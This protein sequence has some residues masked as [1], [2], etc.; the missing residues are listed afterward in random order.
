MRYSTQYSSGIQGPLASVSGLTDSDAA[1]LD[2]LLQASGPPPEK[3]LTRA[4]S[5]STITLSSAGSGAAATKKPSKKA[6]AKALDIGDRDLLPIST[7][8]YAKNASTLSDNLIRIYDRIDEVRAGA[9]KE[10]DVLATSLQR[11]LASIEGLDDRVT[12]QLMANMTQ[13]VNDSVE[14]RLQAVPA[15]AS[16]SATQLRALQNAHNELVASVDSRLSELDRLTR[17]AREDFDAL[18]N[19]HHEL[20]VAHAG[21]DD[22]VA[23]LRDRVYEDGYYTSL[24]HLPSTTPVVAP[25]TRPPRPLGALPPPSSTSSPDTLPLHVSDRH[26][27]PNKRARYD[28]S[29]SLPTASSSTSFAD[30]RANGDSYRPPMRVSLGPRQWNLNE[31]LRAQFLRATAVERESVF[32][33]QKAIGNVSLGHDPRFIYVVFKTASHP[34]KFISAWNRDQ[35]HTG[36]SASL[37]PM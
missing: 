13:L 7:D 10:D 35:A 32:I 9:Q 8:S 30:V 25:A 19:Q 36:V 33:S 15:G 28:N 14:K 27:S 26:G 12:T 17:S 22:E 2:G 23:H 18:A 1:R 24:A 6:A 29:S 11:V 20:S 34:A 5:A 21:T 31:D 37:V 4:Q 16:L 3:R